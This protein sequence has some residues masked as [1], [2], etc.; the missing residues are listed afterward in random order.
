MRSTPPS[1]G[2]RQTAASPGA[3]RYGPRSW[4]SSCSWSPECWPSRCRHWCAGRWGCAAAPATTAATSP[5]TGSPWCCWSP[6][7]PWSCCWSRCSRSSSWSAPSARSCGTWRCP[8]WCRCSSCSTC[9]S[10]RW[11]RSPSAGATGGEC[12]DERALQ[13]GEPVVHGQLLPLLAG[14][15]LRRLGVL[16]DVEPGAQRQAQVVA[17]AQPRGGLLGVEPD[18]PA[19]GR[20]AGADR[21]EVVGLARPQRG[22]GQLAVVGCEL[23]VAAVARGQQPVEHRVAGDVLGLGGEQLLELG[24]EQRDDAGLGRL[25]P[26]HDLAPPAAEGPHAV[27][28]LAL[29]ARTGPACCAPA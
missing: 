3:A 17:G 18:G 9:C 24:E 16:L 4:S 2:A 22:L 1:L 28:S 7:G 11:S 5:P 21:G 25:G 29:V 20:Q 12:V 13:P 27:S 26:R 10:R 8:A 6:A 15:V 23:G 14:E 19:V